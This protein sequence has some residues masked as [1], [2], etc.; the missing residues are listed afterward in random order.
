M[1]IIDRLA[2]RIERV[3]NPTVMGLDTQVSHLPKEFSALHRTPAQGILAYNR[4]L[5]EG[6]ADIVPCVK[7]Q[8]AYYEM[9]GLEGMEAFSKTLK[10]AREMGYVVIADAKR[11][12]IGATATAYAAAFF[13]KGADF[14]CDILTVNGY[15]GRDGIEPFTKYAP[16]KGIFVL[17]RTSNPSAGDLQDTG[18]DEQDY[19]RMGR[20]VAG[21][22]GK[23]GELATAP[24][25]VYE[26]MGCLIEDWGKDTVGERG[27]SA[28][29]AV[30]GATWPEQSVALRK[31]HPSTFFL[32]PGYGAQGGTAKDLAGCFDAKGGGAV[33]NASRSLLA[34]WQKQDTDDFVS[35]ARREALDMQK[36]LREATT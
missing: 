17:C 14:E 25:R 24:Q 10:L 7:V 15:L 34:A 22:D 3:N 2:Q 30:V 26:R 12:D 13:E 5:L 16:E 36:A 1:H 32:V 29:G 4:A 11:N 8:I 35:A 9:L 21:M 19:A 28:V 23:V 6:L 31:A 33:V 20:L 18:G 27:Y